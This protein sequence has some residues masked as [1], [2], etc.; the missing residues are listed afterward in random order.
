MKANPEY[1]NLDR[2]ERDSFIAA[3]L[4]DQNI[5]RMFG[6][7]TNMQQMLEQYNQATDDDLPHPIDQNTLLKV[8]FVS[9]QEGALLAKA[10]RQQIFATVYGLPEDYIDIPG[11]YVKGVFRVRPEDFEDFVN[12]DEPTFVRCKQESDNDEANNNNNED[13]SLDPKTNTTDDEQSQ[14]SDNNENDSSSNES[15]SDNDENDS[16]SDESN[17]GNNSQMSSE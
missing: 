5:R 11:P 16:S 8:P 7:A 3:A 10:L 13:L 4:E 14:D 15:D 17:S 1:S 12:D 6:I 2:P 9:K